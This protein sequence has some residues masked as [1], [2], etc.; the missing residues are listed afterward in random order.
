M[1]GFDNQPPASEYRKYTSYGRTRQP[2]NI[3]SPH[4]T[5][6]ANPTNAAPGAAK[7]G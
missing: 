1:A 5:R 2:K 3:A 6:L 4:G 7:D